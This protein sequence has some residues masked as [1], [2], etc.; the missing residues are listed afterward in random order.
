MEQLEK[1]SKSAKLI[2]QRY[3]ELPPDLQTQ[4][5]DFSEFLYQKKDAKMS[6]NL[7]D[8]QTFEQ[9]NH[10]L[11]MTGKYQSDEYLPEEGVTVKEYRKMIWE[12]E[13]SKNLTYK[14]GQKRIELCLQNL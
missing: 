5:Y 14:E 1:I 3:R 10:A 4:L 2:L 6:E 13:K 11:D 7:E 8:Y 9:W 12:M